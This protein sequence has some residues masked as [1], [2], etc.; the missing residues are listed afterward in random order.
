MLAGLPVAA[1]PGPGATLPLPV[2][3]PP[4]GAVADT[5]LGWPG[6]PCM[7]L[8]PAKTPPW[9]PRVCLSRMAV[10]PTLESLGGAR[11]AQGVTV[12]APRARGSREVGGGEV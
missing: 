2:C 10:I 9:R 5:P 12:L 1:R 4:R 8:G 7:C 6:G 3:S 11:G